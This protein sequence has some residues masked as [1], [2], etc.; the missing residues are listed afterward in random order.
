MKK[1]FFLTTFLLLA[2]IIGSY[3]Q[4]TVTG[5]VNDQSG[6]PMIGA[7]VVVKGTTKGV[8]TDLDGKYSLEVPTDA[9]T[10]VF[11][12]TGSQTQEVALGAANVIDI[13][14][15]EAQLQEVVVT[16]LGIKREKRALGYAVATVGED[17]VAQRGDGDVVRL[18]AGKAPGVDILASSGLSGSGTNIIIRGVSSLTGGATPLFV[19]DG[20]PFDAS[21]NA[22]TNFQ[23]GNQTSSRFLDLDP[24]SIASISVLKGLSA[25]TLYGEAGRNGVILVTTKNGSGGNNLNKKLEV[26]V[27]QSFFQN[28]VANL[29]DYQ[30]TWGGGFNNTPSNAFSNFGAKFETPARKFDGVGGY[31]AFHP[32]DRVAIN[33]AFPEFIGNKT[34]EYKPYNSVENFF[35]KGSVSTSSVNIGGKSEKVFYNANY[36]RVEDQGFVEGNTLKRNTFGFGGSAKLANNLTLSGTMNYVKTDFRSPPTGSS[37]G[38]GGNLTV[39]GDLMYTPRSVDLMGLPFENPVDKSSVYYR[40]DNGIQNPRWTTKNAFTTQNVNRVFGNITL[41]YKLLENLTATYR[42]GY[43]NYSEFQEYAQNKGAADNFPNGVYRTTD[44]I[45]NYWDQT[46]IINYTKN[47]TDD[48]SLDINAGGNTLQRTFSRKGLQSTQQLVYNLFDH[49]NF[50][51]QS[52]LGLGG[53]NSFFGDYRAGDYKWKT[54]T[55]AAFA[56]GTLGYKEMAY[57]NIGGRNTWSSVLEKDNASLFYPSV[58]LSFIPTSAFGALKNSD[59]INF[60]KLRVGYSTSARF[61]DPYLTRP[62]LNISANRFDANGVIINSNAIA[63]RLPNKDLKPELLKETEAGFEA[64][65]LK[66]RLRFDF[67]Y[68]SRLADNQILDRSLDRSTGFT[69]VSINAGDASVSNKGIELGVGITPIKTK[70]FTWD[71]DINFTRNRSLVESLPEDV[72]QVFLGGF[73]DLGAFAVKGKPLGVIQG[74]YA[75]RAGDKPDP[76]TGGVDDP[77]ADNGIIRDPNSARLVG[78]DGLYVQS[79]AIGIIG[80]PNQDYRITNIQTITY[81]GLSLRVQ[82]DYNKGGDIFSITAG[83]TIG[84]GLTKDVDFDRQLPIILPGVKADGTPNNTIVETSQAYFNGYSGFF[85]MRDLSVFD[86]T[87]LRLR[88]AS[89]GYD[90]PKKLL[91]KTPFGAF[92]ISLVGQNLWYRAPYFPR[93]VN[94]DPESNSLGV[95]VARGLEFLSGPTSRRIGMSA[96]VTF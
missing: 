50:I 69:V 68:Y 52:R 8:V 81:K 58:S 21:T 18:L 90:L 83:S 65:L 7:S 31:P 54:Q 33:G 79:S 15:K 96:R 42:L 57:L 5:V 95:S 91:D 59:L 93:Y 29:P 4:R 43:D 6:Q 37:L 27:N 17:D 92:S 74:F 47:I 1:Q 78:A 32:Y 77:R 64:Q 80:D 19:V 88:E 76:K 30:D 11:S 86:G 22:S 48:I 39:F 87:V 35:R 28:T 23:D 12:F 3:A 45:N 72:K 10:L 53:Q 61:P 51:T 70:D 82:M 20:V 24:N 36:G 63:D 85:G 25:T 40:G 13:Q 44:A 49:D 46:V 62:T 60:L 75:V 38:S 41:S 2:A 89:L 14:L 56:E 67:T 94:F 71:M 55:Y 9:T 66:K 34:Y 26:S 73:G 16:A 84:R